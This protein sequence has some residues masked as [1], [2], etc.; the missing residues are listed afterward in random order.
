MLG[1]EDKLGG[2]EDAL[3]LDFYGGLITERQADALDLYLNEDF[4]LAEIAAHYRISRQAVHEAI[5]SGLAALRGLEA[6]LG[7][8]ADHRKN[9]GIAA[10]L[11]GWLRELGEIRRQLARIRE[12][13]TSNARNEALADAERHLERLDAS[14]G[15]YRDVKAIGEDEYGAV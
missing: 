12:A 2:G 7:L 6:K 15:A 1:R 11:E 13:E 14:M 9:Q 3:L 4:S 10:E 5:R 8:V